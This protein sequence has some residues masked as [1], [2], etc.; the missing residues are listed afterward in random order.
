MIKPSVRRK[1]KHDNLAEGIGPTAILAIT[2][3]AVLILTSIFG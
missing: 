1:D 3:F 2:L